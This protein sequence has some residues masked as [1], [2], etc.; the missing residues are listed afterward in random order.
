MHELGIATAIIDIVEKEAAKRSIDRIEEIGLRIGALTC[1]D[2]EALRFAFEAS[3]IDTP[4]AGAKIAIES[5]PVRGVCR[6]CGKTIEIQE[7]VFVCSHCGASDL[8]IGQGEELD[9]AYITG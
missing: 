7:Y 5:V 3:T 4:L 8:D 6:S 2:P 1:V 9:V